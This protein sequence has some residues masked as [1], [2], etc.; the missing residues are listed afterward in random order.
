MTEIGTASIDI[1]VCTF[2]RPFLSETLASLAQLS[3][4]NLSVRV[5]V[6][7]NDETPS[8][9]AL[10]EATAALMP[11]AVTYLHAPARNISVARNACLD[12]A[13]ADFVAFI[14]DDELAS[15]DWLRAL[16]QV[17]M[18]DNLD[19]VFGPVQAIYDTL[20]PA[21]MRRGDFH[22]T[23]PV[24]V[25][26]T[27][28]TGY[29]CNVLIRRRA[30]LDALRFRT[31]LGQSGGEDTEY[32]HRFFGLG[33]RLGY[34]PKALVTEP[35]PVDRARFWWLARRKLRSGQTHGSWLM[36]TQQGGLTAMGTAGAKALACLGLAIVSAASPWRWRQQVLRAVLHC[37]VVTGLAGVRH[38]QIYGAVAP[39]KLQ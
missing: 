11:H 3:T 13:S 20:A 37:G 19:A 39:A 15:A 23:V 32:F 28:R 10:V 8:A 24:F 35:V 4:G 17:A 5:I 21:W 16:L 7:D 22:S 6:A 14:D 2:R 36:A 30:P 33:G 31:E 34:A 27:I 9:R 1:C 12:A 38:T 29:T 18:S 25:D 26:G